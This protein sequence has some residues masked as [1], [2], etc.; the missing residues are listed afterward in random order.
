[1]NEIQAEYQQQLF[2]CEIQVERQK[3]DF[4]ECVHE[5]K[6]EQKRRVEEL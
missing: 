6:S 4:E 3:Q 2:N 1:M 5:L